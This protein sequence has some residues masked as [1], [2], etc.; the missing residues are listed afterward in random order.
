MYLNGPLELITKKTKGIVIC[1][2]A[3]PSGY[4]YTQDELETLRDIVAEHDLFLFADE[5]Y[6][7]FCYDGAEPFSVMNLDGINQNVVL[8]DSVSKRYSMCGARIGALVTYNQ[9][10]LDTVLKFAQARL[11]PPTLAQIASE[12]ALNTP[13]SYFKEVI[14]EYV[15]R[16][17]ILVDGLNTI[18][19]VICPKPSG[20]F[21]A[22]AKLPVEDAEDFCIWLLEEFDYNGETVMMA[23]A[24]GFYATP[25]MGKDEVRIA[26]VL[27]KLD[28]QKSVD[29]IREALSIYPGNIIDQE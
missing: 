20:A 7:E 11:S 3:N 29:I 5:V 16:R 13:P 18:P 23:P 4:L 9:E 21:Y 8:I 14:E 25:G 28:L 17:D 10:L 19:G 26:Y 1:N 22:M 24:A 15:D 2:P 6:R 27:N 12:A